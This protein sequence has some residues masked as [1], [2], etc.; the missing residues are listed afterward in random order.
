MK[1]NRLIALLFSVIIFICR[2][3]LGDRTTT[4]PDFPVHI[5]IDASTPLGPMTPVWRFFGYDEA[6]F[7]YMPDGQKL[8][9]EISRIPSPQTFVRCH[10]LLTSGDGMPALKWSS[11][12]AYSEDSN[13]NPIYD[14]TIT[15][16]IFDTYVQRGLKPYAQ[17]GFMPKALSTRPDLYPA[18]TDPDQRVP[19]EGG[20][21]YP[22]RDYAKWQ[23]LVFRWVKHCV[24]R[25]GTT[26]VA[27][28]YW[29]VW[30]E[31]NISYWN[32]SA[33]DYDKLYDY[34]VAGVRQAL[35]TARVGG[36]E[37]AGGGG[38]FLR[39]FLEH[40]L[41]GVNYA[42]GKTGSPLD[43]VSFHA[44]GSPRFLDG[45]VRMGLSNQLGNVE[46]GFSTVAEFSEL[47]D[48]PI[49]IGESDPDGCAACTGS[50]LGYRN[51]TLYPCY[52]AEAVERE[53]E[54]ADERH[55]NFQGHLTWAFEFE[56]KPYFA[57]YRVLA[58]NGIDLPVLN[59]FRMFAKMTGSRLAVQSSGAEGL[60]TV[61]KSDVRG[62]ADVNALAAVDSKQVAIL[63]WNYHDDDVPGP[64]A[65]IYLTLS[66]LPTR[67]AQAICCEYRIDQSHSNSYT[68]WQRLGLPQ[69]PT[70]TQY[71][72]LKA[73]DGLA[74]LEVPHPIAVNG[75][76]CDVRVLLPRQA[77]SLIVLRFN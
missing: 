32:G 22:P 20:Q 6:N 10:H 58:S 67:A 15:D 64:V 42:T 56:N 61:E 41:H 47:K 74:I 43:F 3:A 40:C 31:P 50:Q 9:S 5:R 1:R 35:P 62:E 69:H 18:P 8:I 19:V 16:R 75:G 59:V 27:Q 53:F 73:Q 11:T 37:E 77:V 14:W 34:A 68:E 2:V 38:K 52:T 65:D 21:S 54:I 25:Y 29:E 60:R 36:P 49:V 13:G 51:S 12:N 44:K 26:E 70:P 7:T 4:E 72:D 55:V 57:G 24:N 33:E 17:I 66:N 23:E 30:N 28:W 63:L 46:S 71:A 45:H 76:A 48:T 39:Q